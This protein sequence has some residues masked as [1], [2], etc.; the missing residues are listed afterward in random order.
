MITLLLLGG[1]S[2]QQNDWGTYLQLLRHSLSGN[3]GKSSISRGQAAAIPYASLGYRINGS[4]E[5]IL[6]LATDSNGGQLWTASSHIVLI[7]HGG[8]IIRSIGLPHDIAGI[9]ATGTQ[10]LRP[11]SDALHG[12]FRSNRIADLP[13][14]G[15]Y[16]ISLSCVTRSVGAQNITIIGVTIPT[17]R[18]DE[19][20]QS[21]KPRWSFTDNYWIDADTGF[22]WHSV[23]HIHPAGTTIQLEIFRPPG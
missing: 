18:V 12:P 1:C 16:D 5:A 23:Q 13:D 20:C 15:A 3:F 10:D 11:L 14:M 4:S 19:T 22:V 7:T 8:R 2:S 17:M 21:T 6:V 9:K